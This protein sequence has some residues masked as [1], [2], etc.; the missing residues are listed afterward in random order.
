MRVI[1]ATLPALF[2]PRGGGLRSVCRGLACGDC[3]DEVREYECADRD[4]GNGRSGRLV[5]GPPRCRRR[6]SRP[7]RSSGDDADR[8]A[9]DRAESAT[10]R[11]LRRDGRRELPPCEAEGFQERE[12]SRRR[13]RT[14]VMSVQR[15]RD[16]RTD[17]EPR[18]EDDRCRADR[19]V[20]H[21]L[22]R[23]LDRHDGD[24]VSGRLGV[25]IEVFVGCVGDSLQVSASR[26]RAWSPG[27]QPD[28]DQRPDR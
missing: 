25:G 21:D 9:D 26:G 2:I 5:W 8:H 19:A 4:D 20:I 23:S 10:D 7:E 11:R 12:V 6:E 27:T 15:E 13:R 24:V 14:E 17:R 1:G 16:D 22:R 18:C 28:E 3:G